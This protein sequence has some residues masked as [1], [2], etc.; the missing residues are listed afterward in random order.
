[1]KTY[2]VVFESDCVYG[3]ADNKILWKEPCLDEYRFA[4]GK[5]R[6]PWETDEEDMYDLVTSRLIYSKVGNDEDWKQTDNRSQVSQ[7]LA[8]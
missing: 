2:T 4:L 3:L 7:Y 5:F 1:M 6:V 8:W